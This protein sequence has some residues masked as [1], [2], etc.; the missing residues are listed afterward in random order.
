MF[1]EPGYAKCPGAPQTFPGREHRCM[2][3]ARSSNGGDAFTGPGTG[4][5]NASYPIEPFGHVDLQGGTGAGSA[6][7]LPTA[8]NGSICSPF[9]GKRC[10]HSVV[11]FSHNQFLGNMTGDESDSHTW[12]LRR[13]NGTVRASTDGGR[14]FKSVLRVTHDDNLRGGVRSPIQGFGYS[15][16][17]AMPTGENGTR[18]R[19]L[20]EG[21]IGLLFETATPDSVPSLGGVSVSKLVFSMVPRLDTNARLWEQE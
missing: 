4:D 15:C 14:S 10:N 1:S 12:S 20:W 18:S 6:L 11:Y 9:V 2:L 19:R 5:P 21:Y 7:S 13:S 17:S 16:L 3:M 8:F